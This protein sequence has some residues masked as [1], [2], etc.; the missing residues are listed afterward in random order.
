MDTGNRVCTGGSGLVYDFVEFFQLTD[1]DFYIRSNTVTGNP[2]G[3]LQ[4]IVFRINGIVFRFDIFGVNT[5]VFELIGN[6]I[7]FGVHFRLGGLDR[8]T[9]DGNAQ[10]D[11]TRIRD[12][13]YLA[14]A[15]DGKHFLFLGNYGRNRDSRTETH[16]KIYGC[17][18]NYDRCYQP[19]DPRI[20]HH[21]INSNQ[22]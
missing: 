22:G 6:A 1:R 17:T 19:S 8:R 11:N 3:P 21:H 20:H 10:A 2:A 16:E 7:D 5:G 12:C 9:V 14:F 18:D 15:R 4:I 13:C